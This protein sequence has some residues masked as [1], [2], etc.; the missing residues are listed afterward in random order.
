M[1]DNVM[2]GAMAL[3]AI[4]LPLAVGTGLGWPSWVYIIAIVVLVAVV[5]AVRWG[6]RPR[7][8]ALAPVPAWSAPPIDPRPAVQTAQLQATVGSSMDGY[9]FQLSATVRW[10]V[11]PNQRQIPHAEPSALAKDAV[12]QR[13]VAITSTFAPADRDLAQHRVAAALG[14][15]EN[16]Q[17]HIVQ[18]S[19]TDVDITVPEEQSKAVRDMAD[20]RRQ[21]RLNEAKFATERGIREYL[22]DEALQSTGS[23]LVWWLARHVDNIEQAVELIDTLQ[24]LSAVAQDGEDP[25][26][27]V[28]G[29][30]LTPQQLA[31]FV[32]GAGA[33]NGGGSAPE[34]N[35]RR[36][37]D[38][39]FPDG[40]PRR[41]RF[42]HEFAN[43]AADF[44]P[45]T[46]DRIRRLFGLHVVSPDE[47]DEDAPPPAAPM[48]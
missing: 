16:D 10:R 19:A 6:R 43:L 5:V 20:Q 24:R 27:T 28:S 29:E 34:D 2:F 9:A 13:A 36:L 45:A 1:N 25:G 17:R 30:P 46:A 38:A 8:E 31:A 35:L 3:L 40:D 18:V 44:H 15:E 7:S 14:V 4:V 48:T 21:V 11:V 26:R 22:H 42:A 47:P 32:G 12:L 33:G 41:I 37:L 39:M 23:A